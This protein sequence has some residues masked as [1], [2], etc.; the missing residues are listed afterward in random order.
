M[1]NLAVALIALTVSAGSFAACGGSSDDDLGLGVKPNASTS[2]SGPE[3]GTPEPLAPAP[4]GLRRLLTRQYINSVRSIFG[5]P[6]ALAAKPPPDSALHGFDAIGA[7]ELSLPETAVESYEQS[8]RDVALAVIEDPPTLEALLPCEPTGPA[9]AACHQAFIEQVGRLAWRRPLDA[10]EVTLLLNIAKAAATEYSDFNA[11]IAYAISGLLQSPY[12]L[13]QVEV[14]NPDPA[15]TPPSRRLTP[16]EL[17]SRMS[18]FLLDTTP[19]PA[20][21]DH[22]EAGGLTTPEDIRDVAAKMIARQEAKA[23]LLSFYA[24]VFRLNDITTVAKDPEFFPQFTP[25]LAESMRQE[26]LL[27]LNDVVWERDA[28]VREIFLADYAFVTPELA[29]LYGIPGAT[30]GLLKATLPAEQKRSGILGAAAFL[31]RFAHPART[32]PTR[33]GNFIKTAFLCQEVPSPPPGVDT[34]IPTDDPSKPLTMKQ[35]LESHM[36]D[37]TCKSCHKLMDPI[38]FA[39]ENYDPI[40][41]F[42]TT[43]KGLPIDSTGS[44]VGFGDFASARDIGALLSEDPAATSCMIRNLYRNSMGHIESEGEMPAIEELEEAFAGSGYRVKDLLLELVANPAFQLVD[45]P[46]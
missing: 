26:T 24:E 37:D 1:R 9:D 31:A 6:A 40:G 21:L 42:R 23:A 18:F 41:A 35:K 30:S 13:Y 17:A 5:V 33:R 46:K 15:M 39:L 4:G 43:D 29:K 14:G 38:G 16:Y 28:D 25:T 22:V 36:K 10:G 34:T 2:G 45:E 44:V 20:L 27:L 32:S 12:F 11:G 19:D 7:A 3:N 8:A